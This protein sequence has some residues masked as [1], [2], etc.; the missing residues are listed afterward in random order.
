MTGGEFAEAVSYVAAEWLPGRAF[1]KAALEGRQGG[2][3][4]GAIIRCEGGFDCACARVRAGD[5]AYKGGEGLERKAGRFAPHFKHTPPSHAYACARA[6]HLPPDARSRT[7][8]APRSLPCVCPWK[9]HLYVLEEE[10]G[11][12]GKVRACGVCVCV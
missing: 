7:R 3:P 9:E 4:S 2:D 5:C 1:V 8:P 12:S 6:P 10:G 11:I